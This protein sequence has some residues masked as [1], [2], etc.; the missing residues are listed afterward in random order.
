MEKYGIWKKVN[1]S[2]FMYQLY[3]IAIDTGK[4]IMKPTTQER[5]P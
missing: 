1:F 4:F 5:A 3:C 2:K